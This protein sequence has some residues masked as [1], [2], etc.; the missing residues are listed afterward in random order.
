MGANHWS[1]MIRAIKTF[2]E[3]CNAQSWT[4]QQVGFPPI[5]CEITGSLS[6]LFLQIAEQL[7]RLDVSEVKVFSDVI[8]Q[9]RSDIANAL[10][11]SCLTENRLTDFDWQVK[12][13]MSSDKVS[14]IQEPV[15]SVNL[16]LQS[17]DGSSRNRTLEMSKEGLQKLLTSIEAANKVR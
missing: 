3:E 2:C 1:N 4:K 11:S 14:N 12:L 15:V 9:R 16:A 13:V 5:F 6:L 17:S 8:T 10:A 7:E